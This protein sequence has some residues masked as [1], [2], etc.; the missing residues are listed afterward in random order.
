[1]C[2]Y[3][4]QFMKHKKHP[5]RLFLFPLLLL[6]LL[7]GLTGISRSPRQV[8]AAPQL[9][10]A[11][12]VLIS[13]FRTR[14]SAAGNDEFI[15]LFNPTAA[16]VTIAG[17]IVKRSSGCGTTV[18]TIATIPPGVTLSAGA[19]YLIGGSSY[20]DAVTPDLP[21]QTLGIANDGGIAV[22]TADGTTVVDQVGLCAGTLYKEATQLTALKS[23]VDQ[24][25]ERKPGGTTSCVD[26][27]NN[28]SDFQLIT[29]N[30]QNLSTAAS[31]CVAVI[32]VTASTPD[33]TYAAN[34]N[35]DI[36]IL[37][38]GAV[39]VTGSPTLLLETGTTD[40]TA[41]FASGSGSDTLVF[42]YTV[43]AG[44]SSNDLDYVAAN[45]LTLNGGTITGATGDAV[46][47]LPAP[48]SAGSLGANKNIVIDNGATPNVTINQSSGQA[49]P[50][51]TTPI[52]FAVQFSEAINPGTFDVSDITQG[53]TATGITWSILPSADNINFTLRATAITGAG[54]LIPS[55]AANV[56]TDSAGTGNTASTSTDNSVTYSPIAASTVIINEV[57]WSG[58]AANTNDEWIELHNPGSSE[59][60]ITGWRLY[61]DNNTL[62]SIGNP[63]ITL[64]GTIAA[65][66]YF[67]LERAQEATSVTADQLYSSGD[68]L[69]GGERLY[70]KSGTTTID[71][72]N[73]DGGAWPAG[74]ATPNYASM[75]RVGT[76]S[77]WVTY[78]GTVP[79]AND[80]NG[81]PIKGSPGSANWIR[82]ATVTTITADTPDPSLVNQNVTVSVTVVGGTTTPTGT[83]AITGANTNCA[84]TLTNGSGSCTAKFSSV[85][86]KTLTATY[87]GDGTHPAS[88]D[89]EPHSVSTTTTVRTATPTRVPTLPPPPPLVAINEF[90]PRPGH[91]WNNDGEVNV[92]DEYIEILNHGTIDVNL[93]GYSLDDEANIG[94]AP[95]RL[96][97]VVLR[98]GERIVFY[99]SES[100]LL[101]SDGGDGVRLLKPNGQLMDAYNYTGARYPDQGY[102]RLPDNGGLDDWNQNCYPTPGLQNS[103]SGEFV[104]PTRGGSETL[105]CPIADTLPDDFVF[106]ECS[107]YGSNIWRRAFWDSTGWYGEKLLPGI[108]SRWDVFAD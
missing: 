18:S 74:T 51:S 5:L 32:Q 58:T 17:W 101:L 3:L 19:H 14:G 23:D 96:P 9:Q 1:M 7:T 81:N 64:S 36:T 25:Y 83:V 82:S 61:A 94:S 2:L 55:M 45:S 44:D 22:F 39:T 99:G 30:P 60:D 50:T 76:S 73:L 33:G 54:S 49:D 59:V 40:R 89:T 87:S 28:A 4:R 53:G 46:L 102:C 11:T 108:K 15:E 98:P 80:R 65:G 52:D 31:P 97:A 84:I 43:M 105:L 106:A 56:V 37:F 41:T 12:N 77:T 10:A 90:V 86:S 67:L 100:G 8:E 29:S 38:N 103:L 63:D 85:G 20:D 92:Q 71:T 27:N 66:G 42:R 16:S 69:N 104:S 26:D 72:A 68:L 91:D 24:S 79:L 78:A 107:P 95:Y 34:A 48:G 57:A 35:I 70:L 75:E 93:S 47:V 62:D 21:N 88:N 6:C 13:E